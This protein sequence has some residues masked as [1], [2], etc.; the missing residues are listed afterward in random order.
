MFQGL[1]DRLSNVFDKLTKRGIL[2]ESA[3]DETMREIKIALLEADVALPVVKTFIQNVK[4]KA[5]GEQIIKSISPSQMVVKIVHDE[6]VKLLGESVPL[7]FVPHKQNVVLMLGLQGSGK[8][9]S[10]AKLAKRLQKE[11]KK[12]LLAS[13]DT[14]RPAA[15]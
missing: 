1:A 14:Y 10:S 5:I 3:V 13:L 9:T 12:V 8:T 11:G 6:L 15:Q 2:T 7:N 4:E